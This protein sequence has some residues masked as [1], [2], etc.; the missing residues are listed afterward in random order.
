[1]ARVFAGESGT[2]IVR[3]SRETPLVISLMEFRAGLSWEARDFRVIQTTPYVRSVPL[4]EVAGRERWLIE[5]NAIGR[6]SCS[7]SARC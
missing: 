7:L 3:R 2:L 4:T 5:E 1:M 6:R